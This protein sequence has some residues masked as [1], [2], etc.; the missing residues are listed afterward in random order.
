[1]GATTFTVGIT[2]SNMSIDSYLLVHCD[3]LSVL[4]SEL[5]LFGF[6]KVRRLELVVRLARV[7]GQAELWEHQL[8]VFR[9]VEEAEEEV[10]HP[11]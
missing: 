11:S 9:R 10:H 1:M 8:Q 3:H 7:Q 2:K 4:S 5:C 6:E